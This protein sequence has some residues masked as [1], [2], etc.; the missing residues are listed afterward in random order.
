MAPGRIDGPRESIAALKN[1]SAAVLG[2]KG[3]A[4]T[5][6]SESDPPPAYSNLQRQT[7]YSTHYLIGDTSLS[8]PLVQREHLKAHLSLLHAFKTLRTRLVEIPGTELPRW[9]G[10]F[11]ITN[12]WEM[13]VLLAVERYVRVSR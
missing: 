3:D 11:G 9:V 4:S 8:S 7:A 6:F 1:S 10:G 2:A 12:R 5:T 13:L